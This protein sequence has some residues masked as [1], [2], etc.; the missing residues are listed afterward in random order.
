SNMSLGL[1]KS[2]AGYKLDF[3]SDEKVETLVIKAIGQLDDLDKQLN[4]YARSV[5]EWYTLHFPELARIVHDQIL[6]AKAVKLMGDRTNAAKLDFSEILSD[7]DEAKLKEAA[8]TSTGSTEVMSELDFTH[9]D[10]LC[11]HVLSLSEYKL[12]LHDFLKSRM[13][14]IAPNLTALVGEMVGARLISRGGSLLKLSKL[15]GSKIQILGAEKALRRALRTNHNTPKYG[16]MYN[17]PLVA[18]ATPKCKAKIARS[19]AAKAALA[20]RCDALGDGQD[21]TVGVQCRLKVLFSIFPLLLKDSSY[22]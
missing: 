10:E 5:R 13:N 1:S 9:I 22:I 15:P 18:Q 21:N 16:V 11:D 4:N 8:V 2:L 14:T 12:Q 20:V 3:S 7:E 17:A 19:L 6:Y